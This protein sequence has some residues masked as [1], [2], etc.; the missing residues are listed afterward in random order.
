MPGLLNRATWA[1]LLLKASC[2]KSCANGYC[3]GITAHLTYVNPWQEPVEG[4]F[5]YPLE[6][7]EVLVG[8]EAVTAGRM[9]GIHIQNKSKIDNCC[10]DC[11]WS[12]S[13]DLQCASGHLLLD[14]DMENSTFIIGTGMIGPLDIVTV[15]ISTTL[16][17]STLP[18]GAVHVVFPSV[19]TPI[20]TGRMMHSK[21]ETGGRCD[22]NGPTSCFGNTAG[23]LEK[24]DESAEQCAHSVFIC[25]AV[26]Q[27]LYE[28]NFEL[29]VRGPCLLAGLESPSHALRAD[30]DPNAT[31]ATATYVTL[32]EEH[33]GDRLLEVILHLSE[34]HTPHI[35]LETGRMTFEEYEQHIRN[36]RDFIRS[37]R[38]EVEVDKRLEFVRK[39]FHKDILFNPVL[40]LNFCPDLHSTT[41]HLHRVTR[42][43]LF[44]IDRS[45]SMSGAIMEKVKDAMIVAIKS[46]PPSTMLNIV[47]FG[48]AIKTLFSS[49]RICSDETLALAGEYLQKMRANMGGTNILGALT[50]VMRQPQLHGCPRQLFL[51]T[52]STVTNAG[53]VMELVRRNR[54]SA[55]CFTLGLGPLVCQRLLRGVAKVTGG[56]AEFCT[57]EERL[58]PKLIKSLRKALEPALSDIRI[59]WYVP[60]RVETLLSPGRIPPLYLGERL[61]SYCAIYD[62]ATFRSI[63][64]EMHPC[65]SRVRSRGSVSSVFG[66]EGLSQDEL[67]IP[68]AF[69][70]R[71]S[72]SGHS[73]I[74]EALCE[75]S[76]EISSEFSCARAF[77]T[78]EEQRSSSDIRR[79]IRK[80]SYIQDQ[81]ILTKCSVSSDAASLDEQGTGAGSLPQG[82]EKVS[83]QVGRSL[84]RWEPHW[85]TTSCA[86]HP[87]QDSSHVEDVRR[88]QKAIAMSAM[89]ARSFSSPQGELDMHRLRRA[90]ERVSFDQVLGGRQEEQNRLKRSDGQGTQSQKSL[91]D[92][93]GLLFPASPLDWDGLIDPDYLFCPVPTEQEKCSGRAIIHGVLDGQPASWEVTIDLESLF[94][95]G[96]RPTCQHGEGWEE[97]VHQ[98]TAHSIIRDYENLAE[99]EGDIEHGPCRRYRLKAIQTSKACNSLSVFTSFAPVDANTQEGL[100][101]L[102]EVHNSVTRLGSHRSSRSGSSRRQ[103]TYSVGLGRRLSSRESEEMDDTSV[104]IEKDDTPASPCSTVS[105]D[106]STGGSV[107]PGSPLAFSAKSQSSADSRSAESFFGSRFSLAKL[108]SS[109]FSGKSVPLG[110]MEAVDYLPLVRLQLASGAFVLNE[111]YSE[112]IHIP[113]ERLKR[114][115]P[116]FS[117]RTSLSPPSQCTS[118]HASAARP[119]DSKMFPSDT[120]K[121]VEPFG[122]DEQPSSSGHDFCAGLQQADSG[123]GSETDVQ[124]EEG[125]LLAEQDL[126]GTSWATAV[127]LAYLEHRC[128]SFFVEWELIAA[129]AECWLHEQQLPEGVSLASLKG[130]AH[131]L[132]LLLRHWDE[133]IKLN[134][135]CYNPNNV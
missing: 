106:S 36:R 129:K 62:V 116:F 117:H 74:Q 78:G 18:D 87:E 35:L 83:P 39:R 69:V 112:Q 6:E 48:S 133:N 14:E 63:T 134:M 85:K 9:L 66:S 58:Q 119:R 16:E 123:R 97:M 46:L 126:E 12:S 127:A 98:L 86:Q 102:V 104:S 107:Y 84:M 109:S 33:K 96:N 22:E 56:T 13:Q 29:L 118:P 37:S 91:S 42:E 53:Q 72:S 75:I 64:G 67:L 110:P 27:Q 108:R 68:S 25:Q 30:A 17:L 20:V 79:R 61:I 28:L 124:S 60:D 24:M 51:I 121:T 54:S 92:S 3:L 82:L 125:G 132:F 100:P 99:Q 101:T 70:R 89:S 115:S 15:I 38:K 95:S 23:K 105:W 49:S 81:Y 7:Q 40:M 88:K 76:R 26:N 19:F 11:C 94:A 135:L 120:I 31:C 50:W 1:P 55:R 57:E 44:L 90:L 65:S 21:S 130:A 43:L 128:A 52:D 77:D 41:C 59:D 113:L 93:N 34:P 5:V 73:P 103:R 2:I 47:G 80:A 111:S 71:A 131:Q 114:A 32:A 4:V 45:G 122:P 8:F 10:T